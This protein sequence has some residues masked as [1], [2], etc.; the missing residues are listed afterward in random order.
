MIVLVNEG[1]PT[2]ILDQAKRRLKDVPITK[3]PYG[4]IKGFGE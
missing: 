2:R 4:L 3:L 1:T